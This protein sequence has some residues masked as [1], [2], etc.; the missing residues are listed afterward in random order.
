MTARRLLYLDRQGLSAYQWQRSQLVPEGH[1]TN[2]TAALA[3]FA[4][5]LARHRH[6]H[7]LLLANL[8]EEGL[9][10]E[11]IPFLQ[12][13]NRQALIDR[14]IAQLFPNSPLTTTRSL[15]YEQDQRKNEKLLISALSNQALDPWLQHIELARAALRGIYALSQLGG[16]LLQKLGQSTARGLL[17]TQV[18]DSIRESYLLD[19]HTLFTRQASLETQDTQGLASAFAAEATK[20]QQYLIGQ[21]LIGR[22]EKL[23]VWIIAHA[24]AL[25]AIRQACPDTAQL[26]FQLIDNQSAADQLGL[27]TKPDDSRCASL[28]LYLLGDAA[29]RQQFANARHRRYFRLGNIRK[30]LLAIATVTVLGSAT[31]A[32]WMVYKRQ[33]LEAQ[34]AL[35]ITAEREVNA[36]LQQLTASLPSPALDLEHL[37]QI[38]QQQSALQ[39]QQTPPDQAYM[40][41]SQALDPMPSITLESIDWKLT[42]LTQSTAEIITLQGR[43][44]PAEAASPRQILAELD[45]FIERLR[46]LPGMR[47]RLLQSPFLIES[48]STLRGSDLDQVQPFIVELQRELTP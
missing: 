24:F 11:T 15:A 29:P 39:R 48:G 5:Y 7:F 26:S 46:A 34:T 12:G 20:L 13:S 44:T 33:D 32:T 14:R 27:Q 28:F 43:I 47:L 1:F 36:R 40:L 23:T 3:D 21:R 10:V 19:G 16:L 18:E 37:R 35:L 9:A 45:Q 22:A 2:G 17:L 42:P 41:I 30:I 8:A 25:P 31:F 6:S 4:D 38:D